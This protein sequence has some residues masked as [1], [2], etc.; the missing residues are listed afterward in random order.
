MGFV[1][2]WDDDLIEIIKLVLRW[3]NLLVKKSEQIMGSFFRIW[4]N[5]GSNR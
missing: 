3:F 4:G 1:D 2:I 5:F